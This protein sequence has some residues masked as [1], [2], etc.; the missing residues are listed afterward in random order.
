MS[1]VLRISRLDNRNPIVALVT[2]LVGG[3]IYVIID[4]R[5]GEKKGLVL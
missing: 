2:V 1:N 3:N 4:F 5:K